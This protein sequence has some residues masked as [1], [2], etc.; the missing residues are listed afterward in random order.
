MGAGAV[1]GS[2]SY[3]GQVV[4]RVD[5]VVDLST[6]PLRDTIRQQVL[7]LT[8][9]RGVDVVID[10]LGSDAFDGAVRS[11]AWRGRLVVVG[12]AAGRIPQLRANYLLVKNI[13]VSGLQISDYRKRMPELV[14]LCYREVF[15]YHGSGLLDLDTPCARPLDEW[16]S[17][18]DE[19]ASRRPRRRLLLEPRG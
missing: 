5:G 1:Y 17:S 4:G 14:Q 3:V 7:A 10:P 6:G 2:A 16:R 9:G 12:F 8:D 15:G 18:L 11:L 19:L 13:E